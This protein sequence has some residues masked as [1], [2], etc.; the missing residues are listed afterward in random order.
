MGRECRQYE[1][2]QALNAV[3]PAT[4]LSHGNFGPPIVWATHHDTLSATYH[5]SA[6]SL[7]NGMVAFMKEEDAFRT[8]V[9]DTTATHLHLCRGY[10]FESEFVTALAAGEVTVD[11]LRPVPL[12]SEL[13]MMFEVLR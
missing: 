3:P 1:S 5:R 10:K 7:S 13:Q 2:L 9:M 4:I 8:H 12:E 11:W 6:A